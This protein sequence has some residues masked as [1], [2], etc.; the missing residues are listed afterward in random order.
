MA[1]NARKRTPNRRG[2]PIAQLPWGQP[3]LRAPFVKI[4]SDDEVAAI[5]QTSLRILEE[6]GITF[7]DQEALELFRKAGAI[8]DASGIVRIGREIVSAALKTVPRQFD[9]IPRDPTK[10]VT[11]GGDHLT[12][13]T[14]LGPP[15]CSDLDHGRRPGTLED[16][17]NFIRLGQYFNILHMIAGSPVEPNDIEVDIRHLEAV[18]L[19]LQLTDKVPYLFSQGRQRL[20]DGMELVAR[21]LGYEDREGLKQ[22]PR[23]YSIINTNS[24]LQ[25][26]NPMAS[27]VIELAR[28]NQASII[29]PFSLAGATM[30]L[31]IAGAVAQSNAEALAGIVLAQL[32]RPG[33]PVVTAAKTVNVDMKTGAPAFATPESNKAVQIGAQLARMNGIP[34]RAANFNNSNTLDAQA[35]YEAQGSLWAAVTSGTNLVMHAAGW[36]EG[37]LCASFEKFILDVEILQMMKVWLDPVPVNETVLDIEEIR[38]VGPGGHFFGTENTIAGYE[39]AFY[40]PMI[41][42]TL[43]HGAWVEAGSQDAAQRANTLFKRALKDYSAP[44][45]N[46]EHATAMS[47]YADL[48]IAQ[49]GAPID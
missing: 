46:P 3:R 14:V 34:F 22:M 35:M 49:G 47:T 6:I 10:T 44:D 19:M 20:W 48:R 24:P 11:I 15:N 36:M 28:Y 37:G 18:R 32:V 17:G 5:H 30:P 12:F 45:M 26:D 41:T 23:L 40:D 33:A 43:N 31:A 1:R 25:Y 29:S 42:N 2:L 39:A 27:G 21:S 4:I 16:Y 38:S 13:A 7:Q 9:L 8:V